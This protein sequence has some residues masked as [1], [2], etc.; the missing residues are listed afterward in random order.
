MNTIRIFLIICIA[1]TSGAPPD[2]QIYNIV[3]WKSLV[4]RWLPLYPMLSTELVLGVIA[5]E[6]Q[7]FPDAID[8]F[9]T[10]GGVG[11]M[12]VI[13]RHWTGTKEE[14]LNPSYNLYVG[15]G[16]LNS[17]IEQAGIIRTGLAAYNCGFISLYNARCYSFGGYAYADNIIRYWLPAIHA[18]LETPM[19]AYRMSGRPINYHDFIPY[20]DST[21]APIPD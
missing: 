20:T 7:G 17:A 4:D 5:Q 16:M 14:L 21:L 12:Q 3:R 18:A 2:W 13:P 11:L 19:P 10:S 6:S 9:G 15:M 8:Q 1:L